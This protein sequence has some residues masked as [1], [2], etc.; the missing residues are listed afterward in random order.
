MSMSLRARLAALSPEKRT[1]LE[2]R[3]GAEEMASRVGRI[4]RREGTA[5][6]PL[7]FAQQRLWFL[8]QLEPGHSFYNLPLTIGLP[9][10]LSV[11]ALERALNEVV[12]R[13]ESL[14]TT[15]VLEHGAPAQIVSPDLR[16]AL[17][18]VDMRGTP[19]A[20]RGRAAGRLVLEEATRPF[21]LARGPLVRAKLFQL[22][23]ADH[24]LLIAM[25]HIVSDGWSMGVLQRELAALYAALAAGQQPLLPELPIQY[26]DFAAAQ[27]S[28]MSG[29]TLDRLLS[30]WKRQL[31]GIPELLELPTDR[32][33]PRV[34]SFQGGT[35][36]VPYARP[37]FDTLKVI[38]LE[39]DATPFMALLAV[40]KILLYR[41]SGVTDLVVGAPTANRNRVELEGLIGFFVNTLVL[42]TGLGGDPTFRQVLA[43]VREVTLEGF[44]HQELPFEKLVE[45]L[46]PD[47]NLSHNPLFQVMFG[48]Q[49]AEPQLALRNV[50]T[51]FNFGSSKFD[52]T[53]S[54]SETVE[55]LSAA[56]EFNTE[57]FDLSTIESLAVAFG[58]LLENAAASPDRHISELPL[59]SPAERKRLLY[60]AAA[61]GN[62]PPE[63]C[64][65]QLFERQSARRPGAIAAT[66]E[67]AWL[68]YAELDARANQLAHALVE[69]GAGA[70]VVVGLCMD[71]SLELVAAV[72]GILKAGAAFL[73]L[74]PTYPQDRLSFM[75]EEVRAPILL[76]TSTMVASLPPFRGRI[77]PLDTEWPDGYSTEPLRTSVSPDDLAYVIYTSGS[78]GRPKGVMVPH[79][80]VCYSAQAQV[81]LF[82]L[83]P[84][85]R[86][87]QFGSL[88]FDTS[89]YDLLMA[90][91]CGGTVCL[92]RQDDLMPGP[93][94]VQTLLRERINLITI[95]PSAL[96]VV[97]QTP[98][99]DLHRIVSGGEAPSRE[100]VARWQPGR[101]FFNAY[102]PTET[103]IW[104]TVSECAQADAAPP[105]GRA[106][107]NVQA[108]VLDPRLEPLPTGFP[109]E[110]YL[111]GAGVARGYRNR[112]DLTA[113]RYGPDPF[114][115][116][117]RL[118][119][120]GD[121]TRLLPNGEIQFLGRFDQQIK[122]RGYRIELGEI[123]AALA[124]HG[125]IREAVAAAQR[126]PAG[127]T[128]IVAY[129]VP[130][131]G[132]TPDKRQILAFLRERLPEFMVPS[133]LRIVSSLPL[134]VSGKLDRLALSAWSE[135]GGGP[136]SEAVSPGTA[137]EE[138]I[139]AIFREILEHE[140]PIG[141]YESFFELG[142]H[143]LLATRAITRINDAFGTAVALRQMFEFPTVAQLAAIVERE[144]LAGTK[145]RPP[146]ITQV[147]Q[148]AIEALPAAE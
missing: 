74:D 23:D 67:G 30:Y 115:M 120:T 52:L 132:Y 121:R 85:T 39:S 6:T 106:I 2:R 77:L 140:Q 56:F 91:G 138:G 53:L 73:P 50:P 99:P 13:H 146:S 87:L 148:E 48:L 111:G 4:E 32:P 92:A 3:L 95:P 136:E 11:L 103:T 10:P 12:R 19:A 125:G 38:A 139:A 35:Y 89:I 15:F 127:E 24:V 29:A 46:H 42:R 61:P 96:T 80:C 28:S 133:S 63:L 143:S 141:V 83:P 104:A 26:G 128:R 59:V 33:R 93:P 110:L 5:S 36:T 21:D 71:R 98:L 49:N 44:G 109:G 97:P 134:T 122:L 90:I 7:S 27:R 119:R 102:G 70:E 114:L 130:N 101:R 131:E 22:D 88:S 78:T 107:P 9:G 118:Y 62:V 47:R 55:G 41:F 86:V 100:L 64:V 108:Y 84:D 60:A 142:G 76:T 40:F 57:L 37:L 144:Q 135:E 123:D 25:H 137:T 147:A 117:G 94:L 79:R 34:Q 105:I 69:H 31:A 45:E 113:S 65:H 82:A 66:F 20:E 17:G 81:D 43:R 126:S 72:L 51:Q 68:T 18:T 112:P 1:L 54:L 129:C 16:I 58:V 75:L 14:R 116:G 145:T 8:D 124:A